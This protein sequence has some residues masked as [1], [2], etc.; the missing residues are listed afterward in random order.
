MST[1]AQQPSL[2][3]ELEQAYIAAIERR[4]QLLACGKAKW[5]RKWALRGGMY[6]KARAWFRDLIPLSVVFAAQA[7]AVC[8]AE[9]GE[10]LRVL[11]LLYESMNRL[12][13]QAWA[14]EGYRKMDP[15]SDIPP[16]GEDK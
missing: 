7:K 2:R 8:E 14:K 5:R 9:A 12:V 10:E 4:A 16:L 11:F 3:E 15:L 13:L 6:G 1:E